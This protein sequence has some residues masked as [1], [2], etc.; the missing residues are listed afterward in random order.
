M[1]RS[2]CAIMGMPPNPWATQYHYQPPIRSEYWSP[3][4]LISVNGETYLPKL[5]AVILCCCGH[6]HLFYQIKGY[7]QF[8]G[9]E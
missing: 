3:K 4:P 6:V 8:R 1:G 5:H 7:L 2:P 9:P